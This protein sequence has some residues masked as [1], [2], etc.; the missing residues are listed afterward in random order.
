MTVGP[1]QHAY[2]ASMITHLIGLVGGLDRSRPTG[3]SG[4]R[5]GSRTLT[6]G[7]RMEGVGDIIADRHVCAGWRC[8]RVECA[9]GQHVDKQP[10]HD[11]PVHRSQTPSGPAFPAGGG[12][13][14]RLTQARGLRPSPICAAGLVSAAPTTKANLHPARTGQRRPASS[15]AARA[16][17]AG[18]PQCPAASRPRC[19]STTPWP[20]AHSQPRPQQNRTRRGTFS[21]HALPTQFSVLALN[22]APC[23]RA[24]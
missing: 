19:R 21:L 13:H 12:W 9:T 1:G 4:T 6:G 20:I 16:D 22:R 5:P 2:S 14:Q 7:G 17:Q 18:R 11:V 8:A 3:I 23:C 10:H 24:R 15:P